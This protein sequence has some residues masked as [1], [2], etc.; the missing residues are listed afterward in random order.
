VEH[1]AIMMWPSIFCSTPTMTMSA[2]RLSDMRL[3]IHM[4][5][6]NASAPATYPLRVLV[7]KRLGWSWSKFHRVRAAACQFIADRINEGMTVEE[8][9]FVLPRRAA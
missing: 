1:T 4:T 6:L 3:A 7:K 8:L 5:G 2:D 9:T